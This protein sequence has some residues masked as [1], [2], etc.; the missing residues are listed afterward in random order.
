MSDIF[1]KGKRSEI[2]SKISNKNTKPEILVRKYLFANGFRYRVNDKRFPGKPDILLPKYKTAIFINGCFWHG[3]TCKKGQIPST[4]TDF[5][6][7]KVSNNKLRDGKNTELLIQLG[8]NVIT[9][10][11]CEINNIN[12]RQMRLEHLLEEL[13]S[14]Q[15]LIS[16][17]EKKDN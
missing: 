12:S 4:N 13:K 10:W 9:I 2:M 16:I 1:S 5:W 11:Q 14:Q 7:E 3:H 17:L 15:L 6:R 8:W